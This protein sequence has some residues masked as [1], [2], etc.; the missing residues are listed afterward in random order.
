MEDTTISTI[1][2]IKKQ[3]EEKKERKENNKQ[4]KK[5]KRRNQEKLLPIAKNRIW[6]F[7]EK[8]I[9]Q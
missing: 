5:E 3:E 4:K 2:D 7:S 9:F 8:S 1:F 6:Y